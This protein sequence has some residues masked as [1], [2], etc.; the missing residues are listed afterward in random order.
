[1]RSS[2]VAMQQTARQIFLQQSLVGVEERVAPLE[3]VFRLQDEPEL[4][5][6][7]KRYLP[8]TPVPEARVPGRRA[9]DE[10]RKAIT[11]SLPK[12]LATAQGGA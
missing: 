8:V 4:A 2:L 1:M 9:F 5:E 11:G 3:E 6:A 10:V 7:E 12:V